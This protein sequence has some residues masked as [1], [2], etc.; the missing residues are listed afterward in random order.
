V[1]QLI[2][3]IGD[4][5]GGHNQSPNSFIWNAKANDILKRVTRAQSA[6]EH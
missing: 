2:T 3:V 1:E 4:Y 6:L 5:I